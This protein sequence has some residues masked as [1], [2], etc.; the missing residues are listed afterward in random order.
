[1]TM[2]PLRRRSDLL[3]IIGLSLLSLL[4][5][6]PSLNH[7]LYSDS[8]GWLVADVAATV[9]HGYNPLAAPEHGFG[10]NPL[11]PALVAFGWGLLPGHELFVS[12]LITSLL[13]MMAPLFLYL[14][15]RKYLGVLESCLV[16]LLFMSSGYFAGQM[17]IV[18]IDLP[19]A[20]FVTGAVYFALEKRYWA[21][22]AFT[23][24]AS[25][26]KLT[27]VP[28]LVMTWGWV[29][30]Y[31]LKQD[32]QSALKKL[33]GPL[34]LSLLPMIAWVVVRTI[35]SGHLRVPGGTG[36]N[37]YPSVTVG[38]K[39]WIALSVVL[40]GEDFRFVLSLLAIFGTIVYMRKRRKQERDNNDGT[41][42]WPLMFGAL[43][44]FTVGLALGN[45]TIMRRY[46]LPILPLYYVFCYF[47]LRNIGRKTAFAAVVVLIPLQVT[48]WF[49]P[50]LPVLPFD[51]GTSSRLQSPVT[52][53]HFRVIEAHQEA[54]DYIDSLPGRPVTL[55]H[56]WLSNE[57]RN[58]HI[59]FVDAAVPVVT[60]GTPS[61][62]SEYDI[63]CWEAEGPPWAARKEFALLVSQLRSERQISLAR[64]ITNRECTV[65]IYER[66]Q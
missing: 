18:Y 46:F 2:S 12:H 8:A 49:S 53:R 31:E 3:C 24:L 54:I 21:L 34:L 66:A 45:D 5:A 56:E 40:L 52:L 26:T 23:A 44:L 19:A 32:R 36:I 41:A 48:L 16:P 61:F 42:L 22:W 65:E 14:I 62:Q 17:S 4:I 47:A 27:T 7:P 57:L 59:G 1:M 10:Y 28:I 51:V 35:I 29:I 33:I 25:C 13:G 55:T 63:I 60:T 43:F 15:A 38:I 9:A 50:W 37:L 64:K 20:A 6:L 58:P 39:Q 11:I 30:A